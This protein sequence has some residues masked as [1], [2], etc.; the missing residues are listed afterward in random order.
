MIFFCIELK[1]MFPYS[2]KIDLP[3]TG[4]DSDMIT[5]T[6]RK[7]DVE[8]AR[9]EVQKIQQE[10][11]NVVSVEV[12]IPA[13]FHNTVARAGGK[14]IQASSAFSLVGIRESRVI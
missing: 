1:F 5:I 4:S 12:K 10:K 6:G 2:T 9:D 13:N 3:E 14:I 11:A 8:K 7:A